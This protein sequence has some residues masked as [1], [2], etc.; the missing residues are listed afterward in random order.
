MA[1]T[2]RRANAGSFKPGNPGGPGRP[3]GARTKLNELALTLLTEDFAKHGAEV[4]A[5]TSRPHRPSFHPYPVNPSRGYYRDGHI[6][7]IAE[8]CESDVLNTYRMWLRY[9]LFRG[10]LS[11]ADFHA[12]EAASYQERIARCLCRARSPAICRSNCRASSRWRSISRPPRRSA[13]GAINAARARRRGD[14]IASR[15]AAL[16]ESAVGT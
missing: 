8:Y 10:R 7:E 16:H 4:I 12:S 14:R 13:S 2:L 11:D 6:R 3:V 1:H 5:Q 15:F 9:E